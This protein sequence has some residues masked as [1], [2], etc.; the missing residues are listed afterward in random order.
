M[1]GH[2]IVFFLAGFQQFMVNSQGGRN[3]SLSTLLYLGLAIGGV[4]FLG[5]WALLSLFLGGVFGSIM[6]AKR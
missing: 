5:W 4:I 2:V 1:L 6:W 3:S